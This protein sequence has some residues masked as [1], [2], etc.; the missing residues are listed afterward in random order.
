MG[1]GVWGMGYG[2]WGIRIFLNGNFESQDFFDAF[3]CF[4]IKD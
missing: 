4:S 2:V 1:Y 3:F